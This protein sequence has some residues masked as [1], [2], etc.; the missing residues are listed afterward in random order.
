[1][2]IYIAVNEY[3]EILFENDNKEQINDCV[4]KYLNK[5]YK[6]R[7]NENEIYKIELYNLHYTVYN[8]MNEFSH[9]ERNIETIKII[10]TS[11]SLETNDYEKLTNR[12]IYTVINDDLEIY[13]SIS[14]QDC[15]NDIYQI[16]DSIYGLN[17]DNDYSTNTRYVVIPKIDEEINIDDEYV[18]KVNLMNETEKT[19]QVLDEYRLIKINDE[20]IEIRD[21]ILKDYQE[22]IKLINL[23]STIKDELNTVNFPTAQEARILMNKISLYDF[24]VEKQQILRMIYRGND[25]FTLIY[26]KQDIKNNIDHLIV[27]VEMLLRLGYELDV[28]IINDDIK[29][30][31]TWQ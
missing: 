16:L 4:V 11:T 13:R 30:I 7:N 17:K 9:E 6:L 2:S 28:V 23:F 27:L 14:L 8:K 21:E 1:M 19:K 10:N 18:F 12:E 26:K 15:I 29:I 25:K 5:K 24:S 20:S 3:N 22:D 31:I